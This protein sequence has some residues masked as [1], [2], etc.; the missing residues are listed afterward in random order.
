MDALRMWKHLMTE[1]NPPP[2]DAVE[3]ARRAIEVGYHGDWEAAAK[4]LQDTIGPLE[5][6]ETPLAA[7]ANHNLAAMLQ[8][9]GDLDGAV[10]HAVRAV[11]LYNETQDVG[12]IFCALRNLAVVHASRGEMR[13]SVA[14]QHQAARARR[15]L[16]S[17]GL[18]VRVE[19]GRDARG[20]R[21]HMLKLT[22]ARMPQQAL[23]AV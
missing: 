6:A 11:F 4:I 14:A 10:F 15:E 9:R 2:Q 18:L 1:T 20:E 17:R 12:G 19:T 8:E 21:L 7:A 5:A 22:S 3:D 13:L 16:E 23:R